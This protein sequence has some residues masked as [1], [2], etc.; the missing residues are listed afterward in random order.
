MTIK[1]NQEL[2]DLL[3][4]VLDTTAAS[5]VVVVTGNS[6]EIN[7]SLSVGKIHTSEDFEVS[8]DTLFD[9]QSITK[10]IATAS[11]LEKFILLKK[12]NLEDTVKKYVP[13]F[14]V[15]ENFNVTIR[16]L[17]LHTSGISDE[18]FLDDY[19]TSDSLWSQMLAP[20]L[21]AAPGEFVE[22]TD[23]GYRILGLCLEQIG[24]D[25]LE[26]L[27]RKHIWQPAGMNNTFYSINDLPKN[28]IAGQGSNWCKV[29]DTQDQ[30]LNCALGCDGVFSSA[31]DIALFCQDLLKKFEDARFF[32]KYTSTQSGQINYEW[33]YYESL[34]LGRKIYGWEAHSS[35]Q[36][37]LGSFRTPNSIEKAGGGGAFV[38]IRPEKND[39][40]IYLTN[41]GRPNPFSMESWNELVTRLKVRE[42]SE[43]VFS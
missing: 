15:D 23:V 3:S 26:S 14:K 7:L 28:K 18:D 25:S 6:R 37:Y 2:R 35:N 38:C 19:K 20:K 43:R 41:H 27:C 30:L 4:S 31:N 34:G 12:V 8:P 10:I 32:E 39:F 5:G 1:K 9:I 40:L 16:D 36:S 24:G 22:Y 21:R 42:I 17:L 33:T 11:L 29:D 13:H